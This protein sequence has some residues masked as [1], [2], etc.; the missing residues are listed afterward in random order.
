MNHFGLRPKPRGGFAAR[1]GG[2]SAGL[3]AESPATFLRRSRSGIWGGAQPPQTSGA[4]GVSLPPPGYGRG[5][6]RRVIAVHA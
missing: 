5:V 4:S 2:P 1:A 6:R 3:E